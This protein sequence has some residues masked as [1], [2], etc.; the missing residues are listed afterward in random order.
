M[1][2]GPAY[3]LCA[4]AIEILSSK[5]TSRGSQ[6]NVTYSWRYLDEVHSK[7]QARAIAIECVIWNISF[8]EFCQTAQLE[9]AE[10]RFRYE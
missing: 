1:L 4:C 8:L 3:G 10:A 2:S 6:A 5:I 9:P 7:L